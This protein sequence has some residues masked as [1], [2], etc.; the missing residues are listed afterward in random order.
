MTNFTM[1]MPIEGIDEGHGD[2]FARHILS[3]WRR[4]EGNVTDDYI[5]AFP[6]L[7]LFDGQPVADDSP[8]LLEC[9]HAALPRKLLGSSWTQ[10]SAHLRSFLPGNYRAMVGRGYFDAATQL[11]PVFDLV[12]AE[13]RNDEG[14]KFDDCYHRLILPVREMGGS[15]FLLSYSFQFGRRHLVQGGLTGSGTHDGHTLE[16][17]DYAN[18]FQAGALASRRHSLHTC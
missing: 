5:K 14:V 8:N 1:R 16:T 13:I 12:R 7:V 2:A 9:G 15:R 6:R 18:L 17:P 10:D 3:V 4:S 11:I